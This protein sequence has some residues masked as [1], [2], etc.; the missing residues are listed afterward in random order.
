MSPARGTVGP[1]HPF[2]TGVRSYIEAM[3]REYGIPSPEDKGIGDSVEALISALRQAGRLTG[4]EAAT[5][6]ALYQAERNA[7][8]EQQKRA[9]WQGFVGPRLGVVLYLDFDGVCHG[10]EAFRRLS[11]A[12]GIKEWMAS[13]E[14]APVSTD[15]RHVFMYCN[16]LALVLA[17]FPGVRLVLSTG[18]V[19]SFGLEAA[20]ACLPA[21]LQVRVVDAT[22]HE[23]TSRR[24]WMLTHRGQ[25]VATHA[26]RHGF[27]HWLALDDDTD[28]WPHAGDRL[29][30]CDPDRG[31]G[32]PKTLAR[33]RER[34]AALQ[35]GETK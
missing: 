31:L 12:Q 16:D 14:P 19:M 34:L 2:V 21:A 7:E 9:F 18:W 23:D 5:L 8:R 24:D 35:D 10:V 33:L 20:R 26:H 6:R 28:G 13:G 29:V 1:K 3:A 22:F 4:E 27:D 25:Q 32:D 11:L 30:E 15:G 17:D